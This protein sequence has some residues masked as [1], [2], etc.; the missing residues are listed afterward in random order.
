MLDGRVSVNGEV[1]RALGTCVDPTRDEVTVNGRAIA[2]AGPHTYL[3]LNKPRGYVSTVRDEQGR[4]TV[5]DLVR[6]HGGT[7][8][9][10]ARVY[11]VGRLDVDTEGLL[12]LT[13]D[14]ELTL[15]L[16]HPRYGVPKEYRALVPGVPNA[17]ALA[18][19]RGGIDLEEG[20][21]APAEVE[22]LSN[23]GERSWVRV[24]LKQGWKRQ[25]RRMLAAVGHPVDRLARTRVGSV[26]LRGLPVG[27][28]RPLTST[29]VMRLRRE[30][31]LAAAAGELMRRH[32][33][34][35]HRH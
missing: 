1:V 8:G 9:G 10:V 25:V 31:G 26:A 34:V 30:S 29:E 22:L 4:P 33:P 17:A 7:T 24:V 14:G 27:K 12:L 32:E 3:A 18:R 2:A 15:H 11:P 13:D 21:T 19:L 35:R 20:R 5:R 23:D 16:T 28:V 6:G